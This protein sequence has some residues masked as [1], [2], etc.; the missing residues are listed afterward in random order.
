MARD[1]EKDIRGMARSLSFN[2]DREFLA[3]LLRRW[4]RDTEDPL[5]AEACQLLRTYLKRDEVGFGE[6]DPALR[7]QVL[8][9]GEHICRKIL[10]ADL[11]ALRRKT[12][13][14]GAEHAY[15]KLQ[16][17]MA[18]Y[19]NAPNNESLHQ[20]RK[21]AKEHFHHRKVLRKCLDLK[22]ARTRQVSRFEESLGQFR[23]CDLVLETVANHWDCGLDPD[24]VAALVIKAETEKEDLLAKA[25]ELGR[26][27]LDPDQSEALSG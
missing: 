14:D 13:R 2:L 8:K 20:L 19:R 5:L 18:A 3:G 12:L 25:L 7:E 23:D 27:F 1:L 9:E 6:I 4:I 17:A 11:K 22:K 15:L 21:A 10:L 24:H 16:D 26:R